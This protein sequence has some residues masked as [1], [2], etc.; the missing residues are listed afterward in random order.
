MH[1]PLILVDGALM[2]AGVTAHRDTVAGIFPSTRSK[3][4]ALPILFSLACAACGSGGG[5]DAALIDQ[6][7]AAQVAPLSET[8]PGPTYQPVVLSS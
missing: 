7:A 6:P 2:R 5:T 4:M 8:R 3:A 1:P